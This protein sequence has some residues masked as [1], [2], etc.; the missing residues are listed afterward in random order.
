MDSNL[1]YSLGIDTSNY[2][3]SI[4]LVDNNYNMVTDKKIQLSVKPGERGLRQSLAL[5]KHV[6]N[7]P[8]LIESAFNEIDTGL[9]RCISVSSRPRP[10]EGSYM[11]VFKGAQSFGQVIAA[12][13]KADYYEFSHQ[14]GHIEAVK[15]NSQIKNCT[16]F[17][18]LHLSGGTTEILKADDM[19]PGYHIEI[20]GGT[21]DISIGQLIDRIGVALG[22]AFPAGR[23]MDQIACASSNNKMRSLMKDIYI[24]DTEM[25]LSGVETHC[26]RLI[27]SGCDK[28]ELIQNLFEKISKSLY[29]VISQAVKDTGL[30]LVFL[31]GGVS[32]SRFVRNKLAEYFMNTDIR[33]VFGEEA[34]STDNAVG[35]AVLGMKALRRDVNGA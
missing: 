11:P 28:N 20:V 3:T 24:K 14:E 10:Q 30:K 6:E 2:T 32:A 23:E 7:L 9:I 19:N 17:L 16:S 21:K 15:F 26:M 25:N 29:Q 12:S 8:V 34:Y 18:A 33:I 13:L 31:A 1:S 22:M 5:F 35:I 27:Q 4:A